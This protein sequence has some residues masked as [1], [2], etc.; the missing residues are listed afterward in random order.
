MGHS[1]ALVLLEDGFRVVTTLVGRSERTRRLCAS[2]KIMALDSMLAVVDQADI[3]LSVVPP[4]SVKSVATDF[5]KTVSHSSRKP[6]FVDCNAESPMTAQ[7]VGEIIDGAKAPYLDACIIGPAREVRHQCTFYVSGPNAHMFEER[8]GRSLQTHILG[9]RIGQASAFKMTFAGLNKGLAALLFELTVA[10]QEFSFL[11]ELLGLYTALLPGVM[12]ALEQLVPTYP[13]H[14]GRRADEMVELAEML[15]YY[16]YSSVMARATQNILA[17]V[18]RLK[19][20]ERYPEHG[21]Q[22]WTMRD[23]LEALTREGA[24]KR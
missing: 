8:L 12:Q 13:F 1:V 20:T 4:A 23:V 10:A 17:A 21:E 11:D 3:I 18:G 14:A 24:L 15:E 9:D 19:L 6:L 16:G 7:E 5:A 22:S 2:A